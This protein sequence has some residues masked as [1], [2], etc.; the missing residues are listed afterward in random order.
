MHNDSPLIHGRN[1]PPGTL[2]PPLPTHGS[3]PVDN[4]PVSLHQCMAPDIDPSSAFIRYRP[5]GRR[6]RSQCFDCCCECT[7]QLTCWTRR[8]PC[9][10]MGK[11]CVNF[12]CL[13]QYHNTLGEGGG[14]AKTFPDSHPTTTKLAP[15]PHR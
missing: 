1:L 6:S 2:P 7:S 12:G 4:M 15:L 14:G 8:C 13:L 3:Y 5:R 11:L 9:L 10:N